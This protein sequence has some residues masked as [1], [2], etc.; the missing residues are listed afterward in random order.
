MSIPARSR[1]VGRQPWFECPKASRPVHVTVEEEREFQ[2]AIERYKQQ[3]G[4]MFPTC[5]E[6]LEV[7]C[8]LG[9]DKRI[10]KPV[11]AWSP[12]RS[13]TMVGCEGPE[14]PGEMEGWFASAETRSI[15]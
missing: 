3:S 8:S 4:R 9:Y 12:L 2:E 13:L 11:E 6:I 7:Y 1:K 5:C 15:G 10:W 14:D